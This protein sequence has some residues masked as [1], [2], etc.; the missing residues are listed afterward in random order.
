[1]GTKIIALLSSLL[2][3]SCATSAS[4][5]YNN[6][7]KYAIAYCLSSIYENTEYSSDAGYISGAYIQ[8]GDFG[9]DMYEAI[10]D[11]VITYKQKEYV[12]KNNRNL[13]IMQCVDLVESNQLQD[14]IEKAANQQLHRTP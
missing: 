7:K 4:S 11:F 9:L 3:V 12:S 14:V 10:R 6:E 2:I 1:M 8:K 5:S 13:S